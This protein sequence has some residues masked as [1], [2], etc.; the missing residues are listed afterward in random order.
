MSFASRFST[1][2]EFKYSINEW[3]LLAVVWA[4]EHFK[5]YVYG[6]KFQ[7]VS[8]RKALA[9]VQKPNYEADKMLQKDIHL[10]NCKEGAKNSRLPAPWR[11]NFNSFSVDSRNYLYMD[12]R[13]SIPTNLRASIMSSIHYGHL[14]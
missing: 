9:S 10:V 13:L 4:I 14:G 5:N 1:D 7:V 12:E 2:F 6:V 8:D 3:E 11:K